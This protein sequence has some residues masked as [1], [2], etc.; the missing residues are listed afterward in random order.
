MPVSKILPVLCTL[1]CLTLDQF[2]VAQDSRPT[3]GI[4]V[5]GHE[6][7][8]KFR[9]HLEDGATKVLLALLSAAYDAKVPVR[10]R[11]R[12]KR[13]AVTYRILAMPCD[14]EEIDLEK[15]YLRSCLS[16]AIYA[17]CVG[18]YTRSGGCPSD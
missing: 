11:R 15:V 14:G 10:T 13:I 12:L 6:W 1:V 3:N 17:D 8:M 5:G 4:L 16:E 2:A 9:G 18:F 7:E